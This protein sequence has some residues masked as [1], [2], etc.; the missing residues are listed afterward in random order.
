VDILFFDI[1]YGTLSTW[2]HRA[3]DT[4]EITVEKVLDTL[5]PV[6]A[7]QGIAAVFTPKG[8]KI[9]TPLFER[10]AKLSAGTRLAWIFKLNN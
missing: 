1:P 5:Y 7:Q 10:I 3:S 4:G 2:Q 6:V 8:Y 9:G